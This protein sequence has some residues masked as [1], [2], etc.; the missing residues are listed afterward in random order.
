MTATSTSSGDPHESDNAPLT[1]Q[2]KT[3]VDEPLF[4]APELE[5][6]RDALDSHIAKTRH[7]AKLTDA[8]AFMALLHG[9]DGEIMTI[10]PLL[11]D[12]SAPSRAQ[13]RVLYNVVPWR[14][15]RSLKTLVSRALDTGRPITTRQQPLLVTSRDVDNERLLRATCTPVTGPGGDSAILFHGLDVTDSF[16]QGTDFDRFFE[17]II[18]NLPGFVYRCEV[19][20]DWTMRYLSIGTSQVTG[21]APDELI[22][23]Q[24]RAYADLIHPDDRKKVWREVHSAIEEKRA[25]RIQ[26]RIATATGEERW[27]WEQGR[28]VEREGFDHTLLEGYIFDITEKKRA[29]KERETAFSLMQ[30]TFGGIPDAIFVIK[31]PERT[32]EYCNEG[33]A[34]MFGY[35]RDEMIGRS[36]RDLHIDADSYQRFGDESEAA[37]QTEGVFRGE[38]EMQRADGSTFPTEHAVTFVGGNP[39]TDDPDRA[40]SIIR[41]ITRRRRYERE[42]E[43]RALHD[44]LTG[45]PNRNLFRDRLEHALE[46]ADSTD[47]DVAVIFLDLDRFKVVNDSLGHPA[48]DELLKQLAQRLRDAIPD[49]YTVA[50]FGGDEFI[51]LLEDISD[52]DTIDD[53]ANRVIEVLDQPC[54]IGNTEL[55]PTASIGIA[56]SNA[57]AHDADDLLRYADVAMYRS[58]SPDTTTINTYTHSRDLEVTERLQHENQLRKSVERQDF[59]VRYQ[60]IVELNKDRIIGVEALVRW[61]HPEHGLLNPGDFIELAEETGMIIEIGDQVLRSAAEQTVEWLERF[62]SLDDRQFRLSINLSG[63]QYRDPNLI[64]RMERILKETGLPRRALTIEITESILMTDRG[65]LQRLRDHG[66]AVAIDDFGTGY[67]SLQY[68]RQLEADQ[69]KIDRTFID[70]IHRSGRDRALVESMLHMGHQFGLTIVSEGIENDKQRG[71][72]VQLGGLYGQGYYFTRPVSGRRLEELYLAH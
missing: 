20:R 49:H 13:G 29:Q 17:T 62:P 8:P 57:N 63:R 54:H 42:L 46:R 60:P 16:S 41:D 38:F 19:D 21:Y 7:A 36:T 61:E 12:L 24:E 14:D 65:K 18:R 15:P 9:V 10:S 23:N 4:G 50:R 58:K 31:T 2:Y 30:T 55:H 11:D 69:L 1:E 26:Y 51:I 27:V 68:L 33:A 47:D 66:V 67:S 44:Q 71:L 35:D 52:G 70:R 39:A 5:D 37:L 6:W 56:R 72:I 64:S 34:N 45:L 48:G 53:I 40:V 59:V 43:H 3:L 32:V 25:F 22:D 28:A